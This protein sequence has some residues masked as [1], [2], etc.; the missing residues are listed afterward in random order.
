[1]TTLM[2][3]TKPTLGAV[4]KQW[5]ARHPFVSYLRCSLYPRHGVQALYP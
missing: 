2:L 4:L 5:L 1:M 3:D